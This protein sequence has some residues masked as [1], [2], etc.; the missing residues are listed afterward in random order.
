MLALLLRIMGVLLLPRVIIRGSQ[1][2]NCLLLGLELTAGP[3][4]EE[5]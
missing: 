2:A 5:K 3:D 4:W 1:W